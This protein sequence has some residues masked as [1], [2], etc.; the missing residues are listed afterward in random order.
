MSLRNICIKRLRQ[1]HTRLQTHTDTQIILEQAYPQLQPQ[2]HI[3]AHTGTL[4][5]WPRHQLED[6]AMLF[7]THL[8]EYQEVQ[9]TALL[10][11]LIDKVSQ[12]N[13]SIQSNPKQNSVIKHKNLEICVSVRVHSISK[14]CEMSM[15]LNFK[16]SSTPTCTNSLSQMSRLHQALYSIL[17]QTWPKVTA[18]SKSQLSPAAEGLLSPKA[19]VLSH[20]EL[21]QLFLSGE[22]AEN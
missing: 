7:L 15:N 18:R 22:P 2:P 9:A 19:S 16:Q 21:W 6:C 17:I 3:Q 12:H 10:P 4:K 13:H 8:L 20:L 14:L 11:A 1:I 5:E